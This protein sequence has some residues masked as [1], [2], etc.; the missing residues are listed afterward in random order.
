MLQGGVFD[1][2][3][4]LSFWGGGGGSLVTLATAAASRIVVEWETLELAIVGWSGSQRSKKVIIE[5][6]LRSE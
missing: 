3:L 4:S 1:M 2:T 6:D 5:V